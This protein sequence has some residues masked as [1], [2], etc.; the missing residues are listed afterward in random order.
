M[1]EDALV[2]LMMMFWAMVAYTVYLRVFVVRG[3]RR[4]LDSIADA[5]IA[6]RPQA[7]AHP[8]LPSPVEQAEL[9]RIQ[10]RLQVLERIAVEK[11]DTLSREIEQLRAAGG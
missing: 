8:A 3:L 7:A 9:R 1:S 5:A 4:K 10:D 2:I 6:A 11:E